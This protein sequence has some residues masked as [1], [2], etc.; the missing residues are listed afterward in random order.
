MNVFADAVQEWLKLGGKFT[1]SDDS[2]GISHVATNY[3][4]GITYLESL[5]VEHVW[6]FRRWPHPG[7]ETST[8][9][10]LEDASVPLREFRECFN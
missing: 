9:A 2:H 10:A 7:V 1:M 3:A 5:G 6:T 4:R 8:K